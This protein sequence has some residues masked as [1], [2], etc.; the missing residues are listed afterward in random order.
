MLYDP[1]HQRPESSAVGVFKE[2][3][4]TKKPKT[5]AQLDRATDLRLQ[6][7]YGITLEE[8]NRLLEDGGGKCWICSTEPGTRRLHVDHDHAYKKSRIISERSGDGWTLW[9]IY[10]GQTFDGFGKKKSEAK[11]SL[12]RKMKRASVRGL[13]CASCNRGLR[14]YRDCPEIFRKAALYLDEFS[15]GS[16]TRSLEERI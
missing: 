3:I 8:Y 6:K 4:M 13:L 1:A 15:E 10:N 5:Q 16:I 14:F 2:Y 7:S 11:Q 12:L 9:T